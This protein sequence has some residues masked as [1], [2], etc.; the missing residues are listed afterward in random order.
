MRPFFFEQAEFQI[1]PSKAVPENTGQPFLR[2]K[3]IS[4]NY[5]QQRMILAGFL[6]QRL[7]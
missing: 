4:Q 3:A 6:A 7:G 1:P 5:R 2:I